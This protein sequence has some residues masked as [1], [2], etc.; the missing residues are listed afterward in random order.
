LI[1][2]LV[3]V[4][5]LSKL[6]EDGS[7]A[8]LRARSV[9]DETQCLDRGAV[10]E[11]VDL[12]EVLRDVT[13]DL[14]VHGAVP[15][16]DRLQLVVEVVDDL[17]EWK[18]VVEDLAGVADEPLALEDAASSLGELHQV[19]DVLLGTDDLDLHHRFTD[20][21]DPRHVRKVGGVVDLDR[22]VVVEV[23]QVG[24]G[25]CG[26]DDVHAALALQTLLDDVHV[27]Q[28]EEAAAE[29][30]AEGLG[31]LHLERET[32]VVDVEF[33]DRLSKTLEVASLAAFASG[34]GVEVAE[35]H[36]LRLFVAREGDLGRF[37]LQGDGVAHPDVAERLDRCDD[38]TDL[39]LFDLLQLL[40]ER[41]VATEFGDREGPSRSHHPDLVADG[42]RTVE[43]ADEH[44]HAPIVVVVGV[45]DQGAEPVGRGG[46]R[47]REL[48]ADRVEQFGDSLAALRAD[49]DGILG[50]ETEHLLDLHRHAVGI[51]GG[52]IDLV[53]DRNE[54][55]VVLHREV[56]VGHGLG[57]HALGRIDH[58]H[59]AFAGGE[60]STH[61]VGEVDV[62]RR[63][64]EVQLVGL[65]LV[66]VLDGDRGTLDGD[67]ALS[68]E[69]HRI[70]HLVLARPV[71]DRLGRMQQPIG[72]GALAMVDVRD[73][74]EVADLH[75]G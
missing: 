55:E 22:G 37:V 31:V 2:S 53:H 54:L 14:V 68:L 10:D 43:H 69:I 26:L 61:L 5:L 64:D 41:G 11:D 44:H 63:V 62:T 28:A 27:E 60:G 48:L 19:A 52:E 23:D 45:E 50:R 59:R 34:G 73:D 35:D 15:A 16:G 6:R 30:E 12:R 9:A 65:A 8:D 20:R 24:D 58:Q 74:G 47:I 17:R 40:G 21:P 46:R 32:R 29:P 1:V 71:I 18:L 49:V 13:D 7:T 39:A 70:Q 36:L 4:D 75:A 67:P 3:P 38:V 51:R 72:E 42:D 25:G 66:D 56:R 57:L 33:L